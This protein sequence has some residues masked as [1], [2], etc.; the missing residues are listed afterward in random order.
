MFPAIK[1]DLTKSWSA[2][3]AHHQQAKTW[4]LKELFR[5]DSDRFNKFC[6]SQDDL[7]FDFSKNII[8]AETVDLLIDLAKECR[9]KDAMEAM[10]SGEKINRAEG[11]E[12]LHTALRNFSGSPVYA[13]G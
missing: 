13:D 1:P 3:Q 10:F 2:L 9:L 5:K 6:L 11:R 8:T 7:L 12:V 4:H